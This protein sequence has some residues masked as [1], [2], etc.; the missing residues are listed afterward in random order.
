MK[1][2]P[3]E[4]LAVATYR[5]VEV[6]VGEEPCDQILCAVF[7][8]GT[9][10]IM[11]LPSLPWF[12][13]VGEQDGEA[14]F[15]YLARSKKLTLEEGAWPKL[16]EATRLF[17]DVFARVAWALVKPAGDKARTELREVRAAPRRVQ[18]TIFERLDTDMPLGQRIGRGELSAGQPTST[19]QVVIE[20]PAPAAASVGVTVQADPQPAD[21]LARAKGKDWGAMTADERA[22]FATE[23]GFLTWLDIKPDAAPPAPL[24]A[25]RAI[26]TR[27]GGE[28]V[29]GTVFVFD[30]AAP[31]IGAQ[32]E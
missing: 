32:G 4:I 9:I 14:L 1:G 2:V 10:G 5:A 3:D 29:A 30:P 7:D 27:I 23:N 6:V 20:T 18:D 12:R 15:V 26:K 17:F 28:N 8:P 13:A 11:M 25:A 31:N 16:P 19:A 24:G 22:A 21:I